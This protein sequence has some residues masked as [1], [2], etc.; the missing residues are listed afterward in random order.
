MAALGNVASFDPLHLVIVLGILIVVG[1]G[2]WHLD[3]GR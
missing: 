3:N 2:L 1:Y